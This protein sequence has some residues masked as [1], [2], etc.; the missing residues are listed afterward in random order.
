MTK[1]YH[2]GLV[3]STHPG[4]AFNRFCQIAG[5]A[6]EQAGHA[7]VRVTLF[8]GQEA[9]VSSEACLIKLTIAPIEAKADS[10][11]RPS[12]RMVLTLTPTTAS[13]SSDEAQER[14]LLTML[15]NMSRAALAKEVEWL[16]PQTRLPA[17]RFID[18]LADVQPPKLT[19]ELMPGHSPFLLTEDYAHNKTDPQPDLA[20]AL[21]LPF[22]DGR[23]A[24]KIVFRRQAVIAVLQVVAEIAA[25]SQS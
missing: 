16:D 14:L 17:D 12:T 11:A 1:T 2:G 5:A 3:F 7:I 13:A 8:S 18:T 19:P 10:R 24:L 9:R 4:Q 25:R 20:Q 22:Q 23:P 21:E 6:L 15:F